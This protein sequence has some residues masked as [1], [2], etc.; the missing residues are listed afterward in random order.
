MVVEQIRKQVGKLSDIFLTRGYKLSYQ[1]DTQ[2][3]GGE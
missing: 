2:K 3:I 1:I